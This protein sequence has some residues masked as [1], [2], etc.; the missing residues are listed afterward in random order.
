MDHVAAHAVHDALGLAGGAGSVEQ[1]EHLVGLLLDRF[2]LVGDRGGGLVVPD[3]P[4]GLHDAARVGLA[5]VALEHE[6]VGAGRAVLHAFV[7]RLLERQE[8]PAAVAAVHRDDR[9]RLRVVD[10]VADGFGREAA[11]HDGVDDAEAGAGE[12][13]HRELGDHRHVDRDRVA[14]L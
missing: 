1:E 2:A 13:G 7:D 6:H 10:A 12:D 4:A 3:V 5:R 8:F 14:P 9:L 11:E